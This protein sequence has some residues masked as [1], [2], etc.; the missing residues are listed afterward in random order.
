[1]TAPKAIVGVAPGAGLVPL[2]AGEVRRRRAIARSN[3]AKAVGRGNVNALR[4]GVYSRT[5]VRED[6]LDMAAMVYAC[7]PWLDPIRDA[8][9][10][11]GV[12]RVIVRLRRLDVVVDA[13]LENL[14]T[15]TMEL[16]SMYSR[17][18]S[19]LLRSLEALGLTPRAAA[20]LGITHLDARARAAKL[21]EDALAP[22]RPKPNP[23][24]PEKG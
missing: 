13:A 24:T 15:P 8:F 6:V 19:Q 11:E 21:T 22:Y 14:A 16:T 17:C 9:A 18:E 23:P 1:M 5:A 2:S 4:S 7:A 12:A 20:D 10:V 3:R